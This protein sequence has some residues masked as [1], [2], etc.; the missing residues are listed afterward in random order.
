VIF[1][2]MKTQK[3]RRHPKSAEFQVGVGRYESSVLTPIE[4][5]LIRLELALAKGGPRRQETLIP[6]IQE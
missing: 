2:L 3:K 5:I 4:L 6:E 1:E